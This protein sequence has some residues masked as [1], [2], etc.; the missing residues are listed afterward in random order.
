MRA[1]FTGFVAGLVLVFL[2]SRSMAVPPP[3]VV[4]SPRRVPVAYEVDVVVI[5]GSTGAVSAAVAAAD[6][7]ARVF[8]AAPR[9]YAGDDMAATLRLWLDEGERPTTDL[10]RRIFSKSYRHTAS[11]PSAVLSVARNGA[12]FT[13]DADL[14]SAGVHKDSD[15][16]SRLT[17]LRAGN[18]INE[19]VQYDGD[20]TIT[21]DLGAERPVKK[22]HLLVFQRPGDFDVAGATISVSGDKANWIQ[23][24][25]IA[26]SMTGKGQFESSALDLSAKLAAETRYV[27]LHVNRAPGCKRLLLGEIV[28]EAE[29]E[30]PPVQQSIDDRK[31]STVP[32][33]ETGD[34]FRQVTPMRVKA[35]VDDALLEASVEFLFNSHATDVLVDEAGQPAGIV[36]ANRAGRQAVV[37]KVIIDATENAVVARAAGV[38]FPRSGKRTET[39]RRVVIGGEIRSGKAVRA[40]TIPLTPGVV[41][42]SHAGAE[43]IEYTLDIPISDDSFASLAAAEQLARDRTFHPG[44]LQA[45]ER[46][47]RVPPSAMKGR[48]RLSGSWPRSDGSGLRRFSTHRC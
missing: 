43:I 20:V 5:G 11:P 48:S 42:S 38:E 34:F 28:I 8:L 13:Y 29:G 32:E 44:Q 21:C 12:R 3:V 19:S 24:A 27:R 17:D 41:P 45:A 26:N 16:P 2:C 47:Q 22:I 18:S 23:A 40:R 4:E 39:F 7:G 14:P 37:G 46:L 1:R 36:M 6:A 31:T 10:A 33:A 35:A 9:P 30:D 25:E 15:P